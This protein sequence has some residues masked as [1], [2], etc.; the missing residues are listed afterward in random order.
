MKNSKKAMSNP[1]TISKMET[2]TITLTEKERSAVL[3]CIA[4]EERKFEDLLVHVSEPERIAR[5][6]KSSDFLE[7]LWSKIRNTEQ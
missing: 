3:Q 2:Y 7:A 4:N 1:P 6:Q 5:L